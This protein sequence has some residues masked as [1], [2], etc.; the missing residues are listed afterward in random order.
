MRETSQPII[1]LSKQRPQIG[2]IVGKAPLSPDHHHMVIRMSVRRNHSGARRIL[3]HLHMDIALLAVV[4]VRAVVDHRRRPQPAT[5][6]ED[7][8]GL[9]RDLGRCG[10]RRVAFE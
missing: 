5:A 7:A 3:M 9:T 1:H 10:V 2:L 6:I 4:G 8:A